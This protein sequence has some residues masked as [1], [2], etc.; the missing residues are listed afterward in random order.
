LGVRIVRDDGGPVRFRHAFVR[1]LTGVGQLW[2][3]H[4]AR[5]IITSVVPPRGKRIGDIHAGTCPVRISAGA[6]VD[7]AL[8]R[9]PHPAGWARAAD[10]RRVPDGLALS[11]RQFLAR[12]ATLHPESR[13]QLGNEL[14]AQLASY[15]APAPPPGT[16][17]E[18][19]L[20]AVLAERRDREYA[21]A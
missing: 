9:P 15:V 11:A 20:A 1:A 17:A 7:R 2:R 13:A 3:T 14:A 6:Q 21:N 8:Q 18:Y 10:M 19:F 4:A 16:H 12:T 5:A